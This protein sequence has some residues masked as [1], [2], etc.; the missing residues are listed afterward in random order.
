M[1]GSFD[2][3]HNGFVKVTSF[4]I[5]HVEL[6]EYLS[7]STGLRV[8]FMQYE[9]PIVNTYIVIPTRE[10]TDQGLPHTLEH[11]IFL[12]SENHPFRGILDMV[13]M[14]SLSSG[15]N[16]WTATD[17]TAY[18][19]STAGI[20]GTMQMLPIY[21]DHVLKPL[22]TEI[23]FMTDVHHVTS[24][25]SSSGVV[26]SE[27]KSRENHSDELMF[28]EVLDK[29][30]PGDSGYKRN[31]GGKLSALRSTNI[32]RVKEYHKT[33]YKWSNLSVV[34]CGDIP[35]PQ[36]VL[37]LL[38]E[39]QKLISETT[40]EEIFGDERLS[41]KI[42]TDDDLKEFYENR[43]LVWNDEKH[44]QKL[45]K[46]IVSTIYF[47]CEEEECGTFTMSWRGP[48]WEDFEL[49]RAISVMGSYLVD[50]TAS[51]LEKALI[52]TD[53]PY[54]S[55]VDF[56]ME[57]FKETYFQ[58]T[59][60]DVPLVKNVK[61]GT[62]DK[63]ELLGDKVKSLLQNIY[64]EEFDMERMKMLIKRCYHNYLRQIETCAHETL[65]DNVI[66]YIIYGNKR[67]QLEKI[68][69]DHDIVKILL[70]KDEKY[71]K[72]LLMKYFIEPPSVI[73]KCMPSL[74]RSKVIER[75]EK[76]L[77]KQQLKKYG[78]EKLRKNKE[79][80]DEDLK[81]NNNG[82]PVDII[83][84]YKQCDSRLIKLPTYPLYRNFHF[85]PQDN[86]DK[87]DENLKNKVNDEVKHEFDEDKKKKTKELYSYND[88]LNRIKYPIQV[89]NIPS[90]F[91]RMYIIFSTCKLDLSIKEKKLM[92]LLCVLLFES[93]VRFGD[94]L[95]KSEELI[96]TLMENTT[97]YGCNLGLSSS[98]VLPDSY[99][100]LV[101]LQ[102]TCPAENYDKL[103]EIMY[104]IFYNVEYSKE[105]L[106]NHVQ[107][108]LNS[109]SKKK[110]SAKTLLKQL[111]N[112]LKVDNGSVRYLCS[113]GQQDQMFKN[114]MSEPGGADR[115]EKELRKLHQ[116]IFNTENISVHITADLSKLKKNWLDFW[117]N[118]GESGCKN[119]Y[120]HEIRFWE[121]GEKMVLNEY[122]GLKYGKDKKLKKETGVLSSLA[123][124]D[125]SY[126]CV[127]VPAPYGYN[128]EDYF[129]LLTACEY[130]TMTEGS[131]YRAI[132]GGGYAYH[133]RFSYSPSQGEIQMFITEATD[134]V[135]ALKVTRECLCKYTEPESDLE[136]ELSA[137]KSSLIYRILR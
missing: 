39:Q 34:V 31:T 113:L 13:S 114:I 73:V 109:F 7:L 59:V 45:E 28:F 76:E 61:V 111:S 60:K 79:M 67:E 128:H 30:Y 62:E 32:D 125:V 121:G 22:L 94:Y 107:S 98:S 5:K 6:S 2:S 46:S 50:S 105:I 92:L 77:M 75:E 78:K 72:E 127:T 66:G 89:N 29:L 90:D 132:R 36:S 44:V 81:K 14:K 35:D 11:L 43:F 4:K 135:M 84:Q 131:V 64:R 26:Y 119:E 122:F 118:L 23:A 17:H 56:S 82:P 108:L 123:S 24:D 69:A 96:K 57:L 136:K 106:T 8:F 15:T 10:E 9:T 110:R 85:K 38:N 130:L 71:W 91:V 48:R 87:Y 55:C 52:H 40:N 117:V 65:I 25:G 41:K 88:Q 3:S 97:S 37:S 134:L 63:M 95:M 120:N 112:Y 103:I 58:L 42:K 70:E 124:T 101:T 21:L 116:K 83:E 80:V 51:P 16:A 54:G 100:E 1:K 126:F 53:N 33:Y 129:P 27:M 86:I 18:T 99:S 93:D 47:P 49:I 68:I 104:N 133:H 12:G 20:D 137:A 19:L 74:E 102:F 115:L